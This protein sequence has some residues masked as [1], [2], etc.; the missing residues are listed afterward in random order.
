MVN[1]LQ[2]H[3]TP[4]PQPLPANADGTYLTAIS[5]PQT[6]DGRARTLIRAAIIA[7]RPCAPKTAFLKSLSL[8]MSYVTALPLQGE[9]FSGRRADI[10]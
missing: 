7:A 10:N 1:N 6:A 9:K 2:F 3:A 5:V 8:G 4:Y